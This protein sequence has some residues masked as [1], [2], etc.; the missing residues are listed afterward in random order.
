MFK[1]VFLNMNYGRSFDKGEKRARKL[2]EGKSQAQSD[3]C[4]SMI[5]EKC[6]KE[7]F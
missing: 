1:E 6:A 5:Q 4:Y 2:L 3:Q 7:V